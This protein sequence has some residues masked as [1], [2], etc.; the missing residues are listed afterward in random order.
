MNRK[1]TRLLVENWRNLLSEGY[2]SQEEELLNE[3]IVTNALIALGITALTTNIVNDANA[4][5]PQEIKTGIQRVFPGKDIQVSS[6][7]LR[8]NG[9]DYPIVDT[10]KLKGSLLDKYLEANLNTAS[11]F[12]SF[13][14]KLT[15]FR[16]DSDSGEKRPLFVEGINWDGAKYNKSLT[17]E[18]SKLI[19][20]LKNYFLF[21]QAEIFTDV[22]GK[23]FLMTYFNGTPVEIVRFDKDLFKKIIKIES[24]KEE[25]LKKRGMNRD[26]RDT[27]SLRK[28]TLDLKHNN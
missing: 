27:V 23:D 14:K 7:T 16:E 1:E 6:N 19:K 25:E 22:N 12:Y 20:S 24:K 17:K 2:V 21:E 4:R 8:I 26:V 13:I 15:H 9:R 18:N 10:S 5:T 11:D 28:A 3:G